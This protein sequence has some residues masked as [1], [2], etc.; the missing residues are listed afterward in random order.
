MHVP[1]KIHYR[2]NLINKKN[3]YLIPRSPSWDDRSYSHQLYPSDY[4]IKSLETCKH[5]KGELRTYNN[6]ILIG[7][8]VFNVSFNNIS[9]ISQVTDKLYHIITGVKLMTVTTVIPRWRTWNQVRI[10]LIN[11]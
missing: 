10:F 8:I 9:V 1:F 6:E 5:H 4:M 3:S 11:V 2:N 7:V